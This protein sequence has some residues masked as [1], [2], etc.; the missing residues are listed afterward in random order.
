M[1]YFF[2]KTS[3]LSRRARA[4]VKGPNHKTSET[5]HIENKQLSNPCILAVRGLARLNWVRAPGAMYLCAALVFK[6]EFI[7]K[8][9]DSESTYWL[10]PFTIYH[11]VRMWIIKSLYSKEVRSR[12]GTRTECMSVL[13]FN[14]IELNLCSFY[15]R[16]RQKKYTNLW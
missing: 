2:D 6:T 11:G 3:A 7:S 15:L 8:S 14:S 12:I 10:I 16:T 4:S 9:N 1:D 5:N 13:A